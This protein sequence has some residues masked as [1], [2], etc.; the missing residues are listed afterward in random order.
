MVSRLSMLLRN[1]VADTLVLD[2]PAA[3]R[4]PLRGLDVQ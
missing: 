3:T 4:E 1:L 2:R